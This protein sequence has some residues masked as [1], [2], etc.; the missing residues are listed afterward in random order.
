MSKCPHKNEWENASQTPAIFKNNLMVITKSIYWVIGD[1]AE[2]CNVFFIYVEWKLRAPERET[3]QVPPALLQKFRLKINIAAYGGVA[4]VLV[5]LGLQQTKCVNP[6]PEIRPSAE[7]QQNFTCICMYCL[8]EVKDMGSKS[9]WKDFF[10]PAALH[11][12]DDVTHSSSCNTHP[13]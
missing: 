1:I 3:T 4:G 2:I 7:S 8:C 10:L 5:T 6:T 11:F 9:S 12:S 13:L